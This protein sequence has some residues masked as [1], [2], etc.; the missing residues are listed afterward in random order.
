MNTI[1][2]FRHCTVIEYPE[3]EENGLLITVFKDGKFC[4]AT[5]PN[6]MRDTDYARHLGYSTVRDALRE[7]ELAHVY[8]MEE[9]LDRA[10][11]TLY[12]VAGGTGDG[13][14]PYEGQLW[15]ESVVLAFQR[16]INTGEVAEALRHPA[17]IPRLEPLRDAFVQRFRADR[18]PR[19]PLAA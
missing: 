11:P 8:L 3:G 12:T 4:D 13:A 9:I 18:L 16:Y 7:H 15:E 10:S 2:W 1:H 14:A 5:R 6:E 19:I 17:I